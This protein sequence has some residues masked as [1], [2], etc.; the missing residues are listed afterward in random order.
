MESLL[1]WAPKASG[2]WGILIGARRE[3]LLLDNTPC[4]HPTWTV[5]PTTPVVEAD[6]YAY[7]QPH[8][9]PHQPCTCPPVGE[10]S[11]RQSHTHTAVYHPPSS[12]TPRRSWHLCPDVLVPLLYNGRGSTKTNQGKGAF[13]LDVYIAKTNVTEAVSASVTNSFCHL[14]HL[15]CV[16]SPEKEVVIRCV[17]TLAPADGVD[18]PQG[19]IRR[20]AGAALCSRAWPPS[21]VSLRP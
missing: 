20:N 4:I 3:L 13:I 14:P 8:T 16:I 12:L 11:T 5:S 10:A 18:K 7:P 6:P 19:G 9:A 2:F 15:E 17:A 21:P 1:A